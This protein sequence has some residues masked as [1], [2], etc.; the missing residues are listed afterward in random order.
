MTSNQVGLDASRVDD[1]SPI[2]LNGQ[3]WLYYTGLDTWGG[4]TRMGLAIS[5]DIN[6][7]HIKQK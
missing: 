7:S 5:A 3:V 2:N 1:P 6:K 4:T